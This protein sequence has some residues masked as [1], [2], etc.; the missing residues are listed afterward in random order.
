MI[1]Y[2][3]INEIILILGNIVKFPV[4]YRSMLRFNL[5]TTVVI[6]IT[7]AISDMASAPFSP[8]YGS[9]AAMLA[10]YFITVLAFVIVIRYDRIME[11]LIMNCFYQFLYNTTGSA[12]IAILTA[13]YGAVSGA[14]S[15][16][17]FSHNTS[18]ASDYIIRYISLILCFGISLIICRRCI[19]LM[20]NLSRRLKRLLFAGVVLPVFVFMVLRNIFDPN[21]SHVLEGPMVVCYGILLTLMGVSLIVFFINI[22]LK[23]REENQLMQAKTEA[24]NEYYYRVLKIQQELREA[25]HDL[26]NQL[27]AY[28]ISQNAKTDSDK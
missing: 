25:K 19:P 24:Q 11:G 9:R 20:S 17:W 3:I 27:V 8:V 16:T 21:V 5:R 14:D 7:G 23:T 26:A 18:T 12:L 6:A 4:I 15:S 22:F 2:S 13:I 10:A 1:I 28:N